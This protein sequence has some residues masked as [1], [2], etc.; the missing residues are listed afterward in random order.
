M[1]KIKTEIDKFASK[2]PDRDRQ[3]AYPTGL[4]G[5]RGFGFGDTARTLY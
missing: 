1:K 5:I 4:G 2:Q 3:A